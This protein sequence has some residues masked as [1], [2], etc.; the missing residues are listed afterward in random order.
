MVASG[1]RCHH[2]KASDRSF[3]CQRHHWVLDVVVHQFEPQLILPP[4]RHPYV[5]LAHIFTSLMTGP[6][7]IVAGKG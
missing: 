5:P 4:V 3:D 2:Q 6:R 1:Y 7:R